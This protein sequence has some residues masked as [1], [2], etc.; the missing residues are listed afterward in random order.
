MILLNKNY[1]IEF[2]FKFQKFKKWDN[3]KYFLQF[4][5]K[6]QKLYHHF[7]MKNQ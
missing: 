5:G 3:Q 6:R 7:E 1:W 4:K 2:K